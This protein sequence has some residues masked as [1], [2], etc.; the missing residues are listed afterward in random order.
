MLIFS[1]AS[2]ESQCVVKGTE[3]NFHCHNEETWQINYLPPVDG[4][5]NFIISNET[6]QR[7]DMVI[8]A[9]QDFTDQ[10]GNVSL[11]RCIDVRDDNMFAALIVAGD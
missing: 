8:I 9:D 10:Y 4:T 5:V 1:T 3:V 11:I 2:F 6:E 7:D